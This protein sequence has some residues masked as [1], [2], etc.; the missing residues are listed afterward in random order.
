MFGTIVFG[1]VW[2][3]IIHKLRTLSL[4]EDASGTAGF[5]HHKSMRVYAAIFL[6]IYRVFSAYKCC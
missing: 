3:Y 2:I 4:D 1:G 6:P 5:F